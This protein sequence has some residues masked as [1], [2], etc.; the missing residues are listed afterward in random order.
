MPAK[1]KKTTKRKTTS[2]TAKLSAPVLPVDLKTASPTKVSRKTLFIVLIII[3]LGVSAYKLGPWFFP[4]IVNNKPI[5]RL[6]LINRLEKAYG[7]QTLE[8][9]VN[10]EVLNL[11]VKQSGVTVDQVKIDEQIEALEEQFES[12][13]GLDTALQERGVTRD[14]LVEQIK[15]Q[16]AVEVILREKI[17]ATD[18]EILEDYE[19]NSA[20]LYKDKSLEEVKA[21]IA[22]R[23]K[24]TKLRDEFLVWF[25]QVKKDIEVKTYGL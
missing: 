10:E 20:T 21:D 17:T 23:I 7:Q 18:D 6:K 19:T 13:G 11:A 8:D 1:T 12:L 3:L 24:Q 4:A 9:L 15:T 16:L 22:E 14:E 2:K 25:S 5:S